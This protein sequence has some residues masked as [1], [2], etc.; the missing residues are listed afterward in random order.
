VINPIRPLWTTLVE[1]FY[2]SHCVVC[3]SSQSS[4]QLLCDSCQAT[5]ER[6]R[7]PFCQ[8]CSRP[9]EGAIS[10]QFVCPNC[11][12]RHFAFRC[13]VSPYRATGIVREIIHRMKYGGQFHLRRILADWLWE[14]FS[15]PRIRDE[16]Y[17]A[18]VPI[19]LHPARLRE[20][21]FN[22]A[23]RS[24]KLSPSGPPSPCFPVYNA[25]A[26]RRRRPDSTERIECGTC[27]T[28]LLCARVCQ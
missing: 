27:A 20:R 13:A 3:A 16:P 4:G 28:P 25:G 26:T 17:D 7:P 8:I 6:I 12:D 10:N 1:L 21:G 2:P 19:P 23:R 22:Q 24:G 14:A 9:Y 18:I 11:E 15:D 5:T